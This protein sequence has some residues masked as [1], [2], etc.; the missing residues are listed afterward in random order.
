MAK[1]LDMKSMIDFITGDDSEL[2][3]LSDESE[4]EEE[5]LNDM[6]DIENSSSGESDD[7]VPL[8]ELKNDLED[9]VTGSEKL[10]KKNQ[11]TYQWRHKDRPVSDHSFKGSFSDPP[12][13]MF[14]PLGYFKHFF[15]DDILRMIVEQTNLYCFQQSGKLLKT[16]EAEL[17]EF[18][19]IHLMMG[20]IN[21]PLYHL[22]WSRELHYPTIADVMPRG[23][24]KELPRYLHVVDNNSFDPEKNDKL[25]KIRPLIKAIRNECVKVEPEE[26]Q[27]VDEQIIPSKT[28]RSKI[29]QYNPKKPKK[30]GFKN[31]VRAGASSFMYDFYIYSG[32]EEENSNFTDLQKCSQV[33]AKLCVDLPS[34]MG[35]KVFFDNWFTT[36]NLMHYLKRNGLLAVGTITGDRLRRCPLKSNKDLEKEGHGATDYRVD[37]NSGV[38][39]V[40]WMD[41]KP[42][43][44]C[45]N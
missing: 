37:N 24:F 17:W 30:W 33:V 19:G 45:C 40:K 9:I 7:D 27:S 22:Y 14:G 13:E 10:T 3:D 38:I 36:L 42:V 28:K 43:Q 18:I 8:A 31:L 29:H 11:H 6:Q 1:V 44:L 26:Y 16:D 15:T 21:L 20:I 34:N 5:V 41:N 4:L 35:Y 2:S 25:F 39:A 12:D 32:K 23:R